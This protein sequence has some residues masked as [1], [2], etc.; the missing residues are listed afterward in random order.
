[1]GGGVKARGKRPVRVAREVLAAIASGRVGE[2]FGL[3]EPQVL[4]M[5]VS[6]PAQ[7]VYHGHAG[8]ARLVEDL[9]AVYGR[10]RVDIEDVGAGAMA[11]PGGRGA[12]LVTARVRV[13]Q[14]TTGGDVAGPPI[15]A[16]FTVRGGHVTFVQAKYGT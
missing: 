15:M 14:E 13:V 7:S 9:R 10:Y 5:P 11:L 12:T 3:V 4:W 16:E 8:M 6:R 2:V 1:M